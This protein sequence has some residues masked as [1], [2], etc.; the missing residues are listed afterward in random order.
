[1]DRP[2]IRLDQELQKLLKSKFIRETHYPNWIAYVVMA[3]K[4]NGTWK[5]C[6]DYTDLNKACPKNIFPLPRLYRPVDSSTGHALLS[7]MD[8][9]SGFHQIHIWPKDQDKTSFITKKGLYG[10]LRMPICLGNAPATF[11]WLINTFSFS[12]NWEKIWKL[13]SMI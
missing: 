4:P 2:K 8:A 13:I 11:Q 3:L 12:R 7:F 9:Y 1:M 6:V 5:M 10:R